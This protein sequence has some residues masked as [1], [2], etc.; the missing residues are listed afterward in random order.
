M[1]RA[2]G[3]R[4]VTSVILP[5]SPRRRPIRVAYALIAL[6]G[7]WMVSA[8]ALFVNQALFHG[9]GIGPGPSL[10]VISLVLQLTMM[11]LLARGVPGARLL[12]VLFLI[13]A[14][15]PLQ[16]LPR[17]MADHSMASAAYIAL[18]FALKAIAVWLLFTGDSPAW[19][20]RAARRA[21][22]V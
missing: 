16:M 17:L 9:S 11:V 21:S 1:L 12:A 6:A 8:G 2:V 13:L 4:P 14:A 10:G 22:G 15:L 20:A 19:F 5:D 7:A 18:G 3:E